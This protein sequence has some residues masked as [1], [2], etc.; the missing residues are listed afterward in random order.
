MPPVEV[1]EKET[2]RTVTV[3]CSYGDR[4]FLLFVLS[5]CLFFFVPRVPS[6]IGTYRTKYYDHGP[7][8]GLKN[9]KIPKV[10]GTEAN[11]RPI[12]FSISIEIKERV[13]GKPSREAAVPF[14]FVKFPY[15]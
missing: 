3:R 2:F 1:L 15:I 12:A 5:F 9:L 7:V 10:F 11:W 4:T 14:T 6:T 13:Q 8:E